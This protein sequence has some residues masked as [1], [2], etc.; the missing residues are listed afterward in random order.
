MCASPAARLGV[1]TGRTR[2]RL[3]DLFVFLV[4]DDVVAFERAAPGVTVEVPNNVT[5][6]GAPRK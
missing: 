5:A 3:A 2:R 1:G 4:G 6:L